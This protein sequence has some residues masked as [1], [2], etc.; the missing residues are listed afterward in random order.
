MLNTELLSLPKRQNVRYGILLGNTISFFEK[1]SKLIGRW[2]SVKKLEMYSWGFFNVID[3]RWSFLFF[4]IYIDGS[5]GV[6]S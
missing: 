1:L 3:I 6:Y 5:Q 4:C 2:Y